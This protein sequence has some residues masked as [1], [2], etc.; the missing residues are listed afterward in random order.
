MHSIFLSFFKR[1]RVIVLP[2]D[3]GGRVL[4]L[5]YHGRAV[6]IIVDYENQQFVVIQKPEN[7]CIGIYNMYKN[8]ENFNGDFE[9]LLFD[10][11]TD[12]IKPIKSDLSRI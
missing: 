4:K 11:W 1:K 5:R 7:K 12:I 10:I 9:R 8:R 3:P 2:D 6:Y